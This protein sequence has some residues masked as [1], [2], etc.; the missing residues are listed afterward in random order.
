MVSQFSC[1]LMQQKYD[2]L[3]DIW[4]TLLSFSQY[5]MSN[6]FSQNIKYCSV[7]FS[8]LY[9]ICHINMYEQEKRNWPANEVKSYTSRSYCMVCAPVWKDNPRALASGLSPVQMQNHK[10]TYR[11]YQHAFVLCFLAL[12]IG[13]S[14]KGA[15][16][17][18]YYFYLLQGSPCH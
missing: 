7:A 18:K 2:Q 6:T 13:I 15:I 8:L 11:V 3:L 5:F 4:E 16:M 12:I 10:I 17:L 9:R 14:V 1:V